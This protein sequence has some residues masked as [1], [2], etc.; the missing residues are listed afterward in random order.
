MDK[1]HTGHMPRQKR[2]IFFFPAVPDLR[3]STPLPNYFGKNGSA[4]RCKKTPAD[5]K[6]KIQYR[7]KEGGNIPT[8]LGE[9]S[10]H[11]KKYFPNK[12]EKKYPPT[13]T[14]ARVIAPQQYTIDWP[15]RKH[16]WGWYTPE[17][18]RGNIC[19]FSM[20]IFCFPQ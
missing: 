13:P 9:G 6:P 15:H 2:P 12:K 18:T 16:K 14:P 7:K 3:S 20:L 17:G 8:V 4:T 19:S 10:R 1:Q 5:E 11:F